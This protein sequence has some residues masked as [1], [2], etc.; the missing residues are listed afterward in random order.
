MERGNIYTLQ[1]LVILKNPSE[2]NT[3]GKGAFYQAIAQKHIQ[4]F[5]AHGYLDTS[6]ISKGFESSNYEDQK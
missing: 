5:P 1:Y 2:L 3:P 4:T 6:K